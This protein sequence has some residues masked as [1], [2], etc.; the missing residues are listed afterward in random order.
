MYHYDNTERH[1]ERLR[2]GR[3]HCDSP[4]RVLDVT[5]LVREATIRDPDFPE[6]PLNTAGEKYIF[7][8]GAELTLH[9]ATDGE[10]GKRGAVKHETLFH[11][12]PVLAAGEIEITGGVITFINDQSGSYLTTGQMKVDPRIAESFLKAADG[13]H[14]QIDSALRE[15]LDSYA[16]KR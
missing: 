3:D 13:A 6:Q 9:I 12:A 5:D 4:G 14:A 11:N 10:R 1:G 16:G 7:A 8:V 2:D 15:E